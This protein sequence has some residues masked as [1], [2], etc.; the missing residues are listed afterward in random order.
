MK[1]RLVYARQRQ[2]TIT[3]SYILLRSQL[4]RVELKMPFSLARALPEDLPGMVDIWYNS[5]NT[6]SVLSLFP[7]TTTV[8]EWLSN[9]FAEQ[10][11]DEA[12]T[13]M[14][15]TE[16]SSG[17]NKM[18]RPVALAIYRRHDGGPLEKNWHVRWSPPIVEGMSEESLGPSFFDAMMRQHI[19]A[20]GERPHYCLLS[21]TL[22]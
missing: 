11:K 13:H 14:I 9:C 6:P 20:M 4:R 19:I 16:D 10:L 5:F 22:S 3:Y 12:T 2:V 7:D 21:D 8:R 1:G 17:P 15:V 18:P